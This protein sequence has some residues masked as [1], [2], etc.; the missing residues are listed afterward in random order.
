M[1][2]LVS[3]VDTEIKLL[4][5]DDVDGLVRELSLVAFLEPKLVEIVADA[6]PGTVLGAA[7]D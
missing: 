3:N 2:L 6:L 4:L 5:G 1:A 7:H